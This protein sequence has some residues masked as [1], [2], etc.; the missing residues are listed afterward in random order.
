METVVEPVTKVECIPNVTHEIVPVYALRTVPV[1]ETRRIPI[2]G[3]VTV[4]VYASKPTPSMLPAWGCGCQ[5]V[6]KPSFWYPEQVQCGVKREPRILGY[7]TEKVKV[8]S[9]VCIQLAK[10]L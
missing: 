5:E 6:E 9:K 2:C 10:T 4:P 8:G 3:H 1:Y 7:R